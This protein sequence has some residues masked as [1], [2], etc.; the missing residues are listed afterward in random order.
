MAIVSHYTKIG[1]V[2][3]R[4]VAQHVGFGGLVVVDEQWVVVQQLR[5]SMFGGLER[6]AEHRIAVGGQYHLVAGSHGN[7]FHASLIDGETIN[8]S[9]V[10]VLSAAALDDVCHDVVAPDV[11]AA[12]V[13]SSGALLHGLVQKGCSLGS[14]VR[15][16]RFRVVVKDATH[17]ALAV[18]HEPHLLP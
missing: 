8:D 17:E 12:N 1:T 14:Y 7:G 11:V 5:Q 18:A 3:E 15:L 9:V 13:I 4:A 10:D 16:L 2:V 6:G